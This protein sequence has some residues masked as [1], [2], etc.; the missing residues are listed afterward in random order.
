MKP[1]DICQ[2]HLITALKVNAMANEKNVEVIKDS[3]SDKIQLFKPEL[4]SLIEK[5]HKNML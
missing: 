1:V 4:M 2:D 3:I 5:Y